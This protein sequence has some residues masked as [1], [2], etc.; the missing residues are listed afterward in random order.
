MLVLTLRTQE[1]PVIWPS[2]A[3]G[4]AL[5]L[6]TLLRP[7]VVVVVPVLLL[8]LAFTANGIRGRMK[9]VF[10]VGLV[11]TLT[12]I[13]LAFHSYKSRELVSMSPGWH[14]EMKQARSDP[15]LKLPRLG[16]LLLKSAW[17]RPLQFGRRT[18]NQFLGFWELH[19]TRLWIDRQEPSGQFQHL[20]WR[21]SHTTRNLLSA[22]SFGLELVLALVGLVLAWRSN[23]WKAVLLLGITL[24]LTLGCSLFVGKLRYRIPILPE[25]FVLAGA[26]MVAISQALARLKQLRSSHQ[27]T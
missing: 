15:E 24:S 19:P 13:P 1:G 18:W 23:S 11:Y 21:F 14:P 17:E 2:I 3:A 6:C 25:I 20:T 4:F 26:G 8:W 10:A 9:R 16:H 5:G 22:A 27:R 12:V 7:L